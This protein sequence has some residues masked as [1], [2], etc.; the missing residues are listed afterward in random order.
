VGAFVNAS[1]HTT[2]GGKP[3]LIRPGRRLLS[4]AAVVCGALPLLA[5]RPAALE[6]WCSHV[7]RIDILT[8]LL[9]GNGY[10]AQFYPINTFLLPNISVDLSI[11]ALHAIGLPV[12]VAAQVTLLATYFLFVGA[13]SALASMSVFVSWGERFVETPELA[14]R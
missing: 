7:A 5:G 6:D 8:Q 3:F 13:A 4:L 1:F 12:A 11:L 2:R 14:W 10:W 9:A